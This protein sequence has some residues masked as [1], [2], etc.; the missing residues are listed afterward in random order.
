MSALFLQCYCPHAR[1]ESLWDT[2]VQLLLNL[3]LNVINLF[4]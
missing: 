4:F 3:L 2:S 1:K